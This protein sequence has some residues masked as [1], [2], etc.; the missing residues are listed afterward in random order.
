M[1]YVDVVF[2]S[3]L[4]GKWMIETK[5]FR[6]AQ[7]A[8]R[9]MYAMRNKGLIIDGYRCDDYTDHEYLDRRFK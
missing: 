8:L 3:K 9:G 1:I 6:S 2:K 7:M 4:T 5:E